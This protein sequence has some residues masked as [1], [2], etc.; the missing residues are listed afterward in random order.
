MRC[1]DGR[2]SL[3]AGDDDHARTVGRILDV[4]EYVAID[5]EAAQWA[6]ESRRRQGVGN[7][8][9]SLGDALIAATAW[10]L[11]A[12]VVTRNPADFVRQGIAVREYG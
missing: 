3:S 12:T 1:R 9:R 5:P 2:G 11:G 10:R 7:N 6:G 8:K 4:L